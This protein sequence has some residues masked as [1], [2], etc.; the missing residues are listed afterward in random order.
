[1][2][3]IRT[4]AALAG[5]QDPMH[6]AV[7]RAIGA[8]LEAAHARGIPV[9]VCGEMAGDPAG[10]VVL[11]GLGI[12]EL[13]M[14]PQ[15]FGP[16]KRAVGSVALEDSQAVAARALQATSAA[17]GRDIVDQLLRANANGGG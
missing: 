16:V 12:D 17:E 11:T 1:M 7:L 3:P 8:V 10:A 15:S 6:P 5:R 13:S 4:D 14:D 9:A 2:I